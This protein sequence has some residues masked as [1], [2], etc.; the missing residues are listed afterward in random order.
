MTVKNEQ[1]QSH[2]EKSEPNKFTKTIK[3]FWRDIAV[4]LWAIKIIE[5]PELRDYLLHKK[6]TKVPNS[7][8]ESDD[9]FLIIWNQKIW[10]RK[11]GDQI[12]IHDIQTG[13]TYK[14]EKEREYIIWRDWDIEIDKTDKEASRR[15]L[16]FIITSDWYIILK[17][18]SKNR[19]KYYFV[20]KDDYT[21]N[22]LA[23]KPDDEVPDD[24]VKIVPDDEVLDDEVKIVPDDEV[25]SS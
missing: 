23:K 1:P 2:N 17:D 25:K 24:E 16:K 14:C 8:L 4:W 7:M 10:I 18:L 6:P 21:S 3:S 11:T 13:E 22:P 20:G 9:L 19:T 5:R 12:E 15:H